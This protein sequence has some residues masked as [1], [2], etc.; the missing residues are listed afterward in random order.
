M[1]LGVFSISLAVKDL[2]A[3]RQFYEKLG[4]ETFG[5]EAATSVQVI[6]LV[7]YRGLPWPPI[8][9]VLTVAAGI[10][11]FVRTPRARQ[12]S[13]GA[14]PTTEGDGVVEELDGRSAATVAELQ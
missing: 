6:G 4:F 12:P 3:S 5:G 2:E 9:G 7:D 1:D 10:A 8:L 13:R 14:R 11:L